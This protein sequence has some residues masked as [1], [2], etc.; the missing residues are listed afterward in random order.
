M[1]EN[2]IVCFDSETL[3]MTTPS[4]AKNLFS[5]PHQ[6]L[7]EQRPCGQQPRAVPQRTHVTAATWTKAEKDVLQC[8]ITSSWENLQKPSLVKS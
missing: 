2:E 5:S 3:R 1:E 4:S 7:S 6:A 8:A